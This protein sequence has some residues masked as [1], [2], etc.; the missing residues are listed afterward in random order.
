MADLGPVQCVYGCYNIRLNHGLVDGLSEVDLYDILEDQI[1]YCVD[2]RGGVTMTIYQV[3]F[4]NGHSRCGY[5]NSQQ[6][7]DAISSYKELISQG[8][9]PMSEYDIKKT[10]NILTDHQTKI[11]VPPDPCINSCSIL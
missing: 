6:M 5:V 9:V 3:Y 11:G 10:V 4:E 2:Q 7:D 8:W 1:I